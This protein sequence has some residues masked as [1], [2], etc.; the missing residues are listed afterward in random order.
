MSV[1]YCGI[2]EAGYGP[3][4]GPLTVGLAVF[5]IDDWSEGDPAPDL[6]ERMPRAV[7]KAVRGAGQRI[8]IADSKKLKLSNDSKKRHPCTHLERGVLAA[9]ATAGEATPDTD[10]ELLE[11]LCG[12]IPDLPWYGGQPAA[13]P[14]G[15]PIETQ[16]IGANLLASAMHDAGVRLVHLCVR[17]ITEDRFN[18][19][20]RATGSKAQTTATALADLLPLAST[21]ADA[22]PG[23]PVRIICDRQSG[24]LDYEDILARAFPGEGAEMSMRTNHASRYLLRDGRVAVNFETQAEDRH[25]PTALASMAAK[26]VRELLMARMN[27]YFRAR[28]PEL[29]PTAGYVQDARRWLRDA[30]GILAP[31]ER[32]KMVRL[33]CAPS[34]TQPRGCTTGGTWTWRRGPRC[35]PRAMSSPTP[36]SGR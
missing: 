19:I 31:K 7:C 29:K 30:E 6:W 15:E 3:M 8:P 35:G 12:E 2:D 25:L 22:E 11:L 10:A 24:R 4:L 36:W 26:F 1:L 17:T 23:T 14:L 5:A 9:L 27:R 13:L 16:R 32:T 21:L 34:P 20:V 33:A 18:E 28:M